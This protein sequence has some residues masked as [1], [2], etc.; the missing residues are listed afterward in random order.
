M[1][2][3]ENKDLINTDNMSTQ[4]GLFAGI[5]MAA[6]LLLFQFAGLDYSPFLKLSK[7][8]L[9]A[10]PIVISLNIYKKKLNEDVFVKGFGLGAK[11][12]LAA[13]IS[14]A[15]INFIIFAISPE[16][17]FSKYTI[18]PTSLPQVG[19]IS[20]VLF[21]EVFVIGGIITFITLQYLKEK[22]RR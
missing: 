14:L 12:S 22:S 7:Y 20:A 19:L 15:V 4:Y 1:S 21:I 11:L 18:E 10:F 6:T 17:A 16:Y 3:I 13:G 2:T 8:L 9:L 5:L